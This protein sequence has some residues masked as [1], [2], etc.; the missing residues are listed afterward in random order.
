MKFASDLD[1]FQFMERDFY[2]GALSDILDEMGFRKCAA[3]PHALIRPL[4]P[5]AVCAGRVRT[6]LNAPGR[7]GR[8]NPYKM[9]IALI[10]SLKPGDIAVATATQ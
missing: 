2:S 5:R 10:D 8:E 1:L 4:D 6:L 3:S 7:T 9:A